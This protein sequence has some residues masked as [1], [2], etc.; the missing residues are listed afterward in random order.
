MTNP[1]C[2]RWWWLGNPSWLWS[3]GIGTL[4]GNIVCFTLPNSCTAGRDLAWRRCCK[5][6]YCHGEI[7]YSW[8]EQL[9]W[10]S[11]PPDTR[12]APFPLAVPLTQT[13]LLFC[14]MPPDPSKR[15]EHI[16]GSD[17]ALSSCNLRSP[18]WCL[19]Q[20][21]LCASCVKH[22]DIPQELLIYFANSALLCGSQTSNGLWSSNILKLN[23]RS[24]KNLLYYMK[25]LTLSTCWVF[26]S[27][28]AD[29]LQIEFVKLRR[30]GP[31][32]VNAIV[33]LGK[34]KKM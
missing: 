32:L 9:S 25:D 24:F 8:V 29:L 19:T 15:G 22:Q 20:S 31:G 28:K 14:G 13:E 11:P 17:A 16:P 2:W 30:P 33:K 12:W 18:P 10:S 34:E 7:V 26:G 1:S 5:C 4:A 6:F 3:P 27:W 21:L 23:S